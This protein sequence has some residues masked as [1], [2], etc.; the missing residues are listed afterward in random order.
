MAGFDNIQVGD[1]VADAEKPMALD[2]IVIEEPTVKMEFSV[3]TS[4]FAGQKRKYVTSRNLRDRLFKEM[5][6]NISLN[7][8]ETQSPDSFI[9]S[10]RGELHL[11]VLIET[12]RREGY[13]FQVSRPEVIIREINGVRYEPYEFLTISTLLDYQGVVIE[14][15][16]AR[17]GLLQNMMSTTQKKG[18]FEYLIP[19]RNLIGLKN[20]L[21]AKTQGNIILHHI[22]YDYRPISISEDKNNSK[23]S[24]ISWEN[25]EATAYGISKAQE[26]GVCLLI[27]EKKFMKE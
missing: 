9:V 21:I 26:R 19:T 24:L 27:R 7:V 17:G 20:E 25:G 15:L 1:T 8:K 3:N 22:F 4:P 13:E 6:T 23:G 2:P 10:G 14:V 18:Y 5:E 12:M 11:T 16:G